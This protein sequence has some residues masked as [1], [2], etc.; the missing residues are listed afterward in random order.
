M[1]LCY[2]LTNKI[3]SQQIQVG[4]LRQT[5]ALSEKADIT[6]TTAVIENRLKKNWPQ[7]VETCRFTETN[8]YIKQ[9]KYIS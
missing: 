7:A 8:P 6:T 2:K 4:G 9:Y 3:T 5:T 1:H